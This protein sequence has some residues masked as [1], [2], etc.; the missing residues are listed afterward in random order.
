MKM[1][2]ERRSEII[3]KNRTFYH[4]SHWAEKAIREL[5]AEVQRLK[6]KCKEPDHA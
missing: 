3:R 1:K 4:G 6:R 2:D 5:L